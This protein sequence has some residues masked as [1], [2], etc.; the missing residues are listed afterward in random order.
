MEVFVCVVVIVVIDIFCVLVFF[1]FIEI[2]VI[3][4][5]IF[6]DEICICKVVVGFF[7]VCVDEVLEGKVEEMGGNDVFEEFDGVDED[8]FDI[9]W[10]E[11]VNIKCLVEMFVIYDV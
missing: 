10:R 2:D 6:D 3:G 5:L 9:F 4:I 7:V 11:W 8:I 1:E